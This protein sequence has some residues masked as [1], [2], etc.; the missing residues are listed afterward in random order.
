MMT[1]GAGENLNVTE[2]TTATSSTPLLSDGVLSS[3]FNSSSER[4]ASSEQRKSFLLSV[5]KKDGPPQIILLIFLLAL[6]FGSTIGVVRPC[7]IPLT[8]P[9]LL[10]TIVFASPGPGCHDGSLCST[11]PWI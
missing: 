6:A 10:I 1:D 7:V 11:E 4:R 8:A 9:L 3:E 5:V 2:E